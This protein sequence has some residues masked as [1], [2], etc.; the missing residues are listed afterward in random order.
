MMKKV[1]FTGGG[2]AGHVTV[3]LALIPKFQREG[4]ETHYIGS[5]QGI[6]RELVEKLD[7]VHYHWVSTGKLRRYL[8]LENLKDPFKVLKGIWDAYRVI[9]RHKPNVIFSKGGF[10]T[11]P[12]VIGAWL[13]RVPVL[14]HESDL[15]PGLANRLAVPFASKVFT[16][17]PETANYVK[18]NKTQYLGAIVR[19]E[20]KRGDADRGRQ[21]CQLTGDK[22]VLLVMGGSLGSQKL[23]ELIRHNLPAL[24]ERF[25]VIHLCGKNQLAPDLDVEGYRQYEYVNEELPDLLHLADVIVS[26]AGSNAIF[27]FLSLRKPMLLIPLS[28]AASRGDQILNAKS[29]QKQGFADVIEEEE[30]TE[31][32]FLGQLN[33]LFESKEIYIE[34]MSKIETDQAL[35][36]VFQSIK[37]HAK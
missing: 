7:D 31:E 5:R 21:F 10:V 4:W 32:R 33:Q 20:L 3:N 17:F 36:Q 12:V 26:R 23:N 13:N 28:R 6:E 15:T 18:S 8:S 9:R 25:Q 30:L 11:V 27:E 1:L 24:T 14:I 22:P 29:F 34:N 37:E 2:T 35:E 19:D 16:T